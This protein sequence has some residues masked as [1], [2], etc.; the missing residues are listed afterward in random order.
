MNSKVVLFCLTYNA[1]ML[2]S[3]SM[4]L[5]SSFDVLQHNFTEQFRFLTLQPLQAEG[6]LST[7]QLQ[8]K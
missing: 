1:N 7:L 2:E 8:G 5:L 6:G 3:K 4:S